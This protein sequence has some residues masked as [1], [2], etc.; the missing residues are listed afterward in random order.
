M[1]VYV[2]GVSVNGHLENGTPASYALRTAGGDV[3]ATREDAYESSH[4]DLTGRLLHFGKKT[5]MQDVLMDLLKSKSADK[6]QGQPSS[7]AIVATL[8]IK[9]LQA[10]GSSRQWKILK[11]KP[12]GVSTGEHTAKPKAILASGSSMGEQTV[13]PKTLLKRPT[14]SSVPADID[15]QD[16]SEKLAEQID[17]KTISEYDSLLSG[18]SSL[19]E[20]AFL[21]N[22]ARMM[23]IVDQ[24]NERLDTV[25]RFRQEQLLRLLSNCINEYLPEAIN[26]AMAREFDEI[27]IDFENAVEKSLKAASKNAVS[28]AIPKAVSAVVE[29]SKGELSQVTADNLGK[30]LT[31]SEVRQAFTKAFEELLLPSFEEST[32]TFLAS[33]ARAI[34]SEVETKI[35]KTL[36]Q[37][38]AD[39]EKETLNLKSSLEEVASIL[40]ASST[41]A[42]KGVAPTDRSSSGLT[43]KLKEFIQAEKFIDALK[44]SASSG[45]KTIALEAVSM[46]LDSS[47]EPERASDGLSPSEMVYIMEAISTGTSNLPARL[48]WLSDLSVIFVEAAQEASEQNAEFTY[49]CDLLENV[50]K[51]TMGVSVD[52][53]DRD[54]GKA[55]KLVV[56]LLNSQVRMNKASQ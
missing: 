14:Q 35:T 15:A 41:G 56:H 24:E 19:C 17:E 5:S 29:N 52:G 3:L 30:L 28:E 4:R 12:S 32:R 7:K 54:A 25:F 9:A 31:K 34:S 18:L 46:I 53:L 20:E 45:D 21:D 37:G 2:E 50:V 47:S 36:R 6:S 16:D 22:E 13:K 8:V 1:E 43:A 40:Q 55:K 26:T 42:E 10:S 49:P 48:K 33:F 39:L 51:N 38:V 27:S 23:E 44:L 11:R